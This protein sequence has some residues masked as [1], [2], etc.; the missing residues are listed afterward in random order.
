MI[1]SNVSANVSHVL[2][3]IFYDVTGYLEPD[4]GYCLFR[5]THLVSKIPNR[6]IF[7]EGGKTVYL[8]QNILSII[9]NC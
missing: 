8:I 3:L 6:P 9:L 7:P 5:E 4:V 1:V 2:T